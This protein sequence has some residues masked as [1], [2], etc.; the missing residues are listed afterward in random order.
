MCGGGPRLALWHLRSL[1]PAA[2]CDLTAVA[3][4]ARFHDGLVL[5]GG[6]AA[7]LHQFSFSGE[8]SG[9]ITTDCSAVFT[10]LARTQPSKVGQG[11]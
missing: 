11:L 4:V 6:D 7:D 9:T 2:V 1:T 3:H 10:V 8:R 5:A